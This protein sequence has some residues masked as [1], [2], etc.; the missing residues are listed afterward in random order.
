MRTGTKSIDLI[1]NKKDKLARAARVFVL[2]FA[3]V[4]LD[5]NAVLHGQRWCYTRRFLVQH[6]VATLM[7]H[8]CDIVSNSYN[9]VPTLQRCVA[10]KIVFSLWKSEWPCDIPPKTPR[11]ACD[12]ISVNW[13]ILHWYACDTDG[14]SGHVITKKRRFAMTI[15]SATQR[16]N[17]VATLFRMV[18]T[19]SQHCNAVLCWKSSLRI[20]PC[21]ISLYIDDPLALAVNKSPAV[22]VVYHAHSRD[23]E[24]KIEGLWLRQERA[25]DSG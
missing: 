2:F 9:I 25:P 14:R 20:V 18:T 5:D 7:Q 1:L 23:F 15:F 3:F 21:N 10:L 17:I 16:C 22:F 19:L 13:V 12:I 24:E 8:C 11:V 6:S 4:L